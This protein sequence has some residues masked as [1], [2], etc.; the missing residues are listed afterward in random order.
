MLD[1][2]DQFKDFDSEKLETYPLPLDPCPEDANRLV[3]DEAE[4]EPLLNVFRGWRW[5]RSAR[6]VNVTVLNGTV[7]DE[8]Q[9]ARAWPPTSAVRCSRWASR[10]GRPT[11]P[12]PS[13]PRPRST[14]RPVRG[15]YAQRVARHITSAAAIPEVGPRPG[16]GT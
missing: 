13:T 3:L 2:A 15:C 11:T 5:A 7:A 4:A 12:T 16:P 14:T 9:S 8:A 10:W 6:V 1:L